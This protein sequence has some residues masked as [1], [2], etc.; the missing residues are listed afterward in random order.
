[1]LVHGAGDLG[2]HDWRVSGRGERRGGGDRCRPPAAVATLAQLVIVQAACELRLL[3][4]G[5]DV[6][7]GH[8][9]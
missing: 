9:L 1:M 7:V 6:L 4:V 8:L 3:Q 5:R 2:G